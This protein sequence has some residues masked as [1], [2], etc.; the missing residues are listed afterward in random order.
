MTRQRTSVSKQPA[1][2]CAVYTR[3]STSEGLEQ[4]FNTLDAQ[5]EAGEAYI[6]SQ[7]QEGWTC[8]PERYDEGGFTGGNTDRPALRQLLADIEAGKI[9]CVMVYKVDRFSRSLLDF[10]KMMEHFE[11]HGV[12]FV[13]VTQHF[14]TAQS[15]GRLTLNVLLSFAQFEREIIAERTRDKIAAA[16]RKGR[17]CGGAPLL[18][19]DVTLE[20]GRLVVND[21]EAQ[22]M[23]DIFGLYL[24]LGSL[25]EVVRE[26]DRRGWRTKSW[27]T[28]KGRP[29][30]G[31]PFTKT[32]QLLT[33]VTYLG[34]VKYKDEVH[35][36]RHDSIVPKELFREV[37]QRLRRNRRFD[38]S[39]N[40][41]SSC[42]LRPLQGL[43]YCGA[44]SC[45]MTHTYT[46]KGNRRYRYY[47]CLDAQKRG[48]DQCPS[49][50]IPAAQVE[51]FIA[52]ELQTHRGGAVDWESLTTDQRAGLLRGAVKRVEYNGNEIAI[53]F[54][55][56]SGENDG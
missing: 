26:L 1:M 15:M 9:D 48:W 41:A 53:T 14:N 20:S 28:R 6:A 32:H 12:S 37:Q 55:D 16:R 40:D 2:R 38:G 19:Y 35:P 42:A 25:L 49:K 43:L 47:V 7:A 18:G 23:R 3:K 29:R 39:V 21:E 31:K 44:C 24:Q 34:Q 17:W 5:R 36:G 51:R 27:T 54:H 45:P 11:Q 4:E 52:N 33:N 56:T 10:A 22:R 8:L 50:A 30:G 13:S 46:S